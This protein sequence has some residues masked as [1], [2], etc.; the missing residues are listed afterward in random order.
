MGS[1]IRQYLDRILAAVMAGAT[2]LVLPIALLLS[3]QWPLR[4]L[5]RACSREANNMA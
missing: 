4:D 5:L 1:A 3:L 2:W